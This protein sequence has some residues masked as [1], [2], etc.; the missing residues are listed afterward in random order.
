MEIFKDIK[1]YE[2]SY[3]ISNLGRIKSLSRLVDNHSGFK[4]NL[5][6][7]MLKTHI[8]KTG[9][10]VVDLKKENIRKT[11]KVHRLI[12]IHFINKIEGKKYI[13]HIDGNK[14]NNNISNLEWC[15]IKE[16]NNHAKLNKLKND[17]GH[18][19]SRACFTEN[20]SE[21]IRNSEKSIKDLSFFY[22]VNFSTIYRIKKGIT[23]KK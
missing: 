16:N 22:N 6:E 23:Y 8:S 21:L 11:F 4:K 2:G 9:Y 5:K 12:A 1:G 3:Q 15:T 14:L 17:C 7:K 18:N 20:Q 10:F 19:N 13:N